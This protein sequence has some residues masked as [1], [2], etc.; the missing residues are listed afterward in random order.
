MIC[1]NSLM[2]THYCLLTGFGLLLSITSF[3]FVL[4][5]QPRRGRMLMLAFVFVGLILPKLL[6]FVVEISVAMS[7]FGFSDPNILWI[8]RLVTATTWICRLVGS[9]LLLSY[10]IC[11]ARVKPNMPFSERSNDAPH[12]YEQ[13]DLQNNFA[14]TQTKSLPPSGPSW[15]V[16]PAPKLNVKIL[17]QREWGFIID[18]LPF[19][20][21]N[22]VIILIISTQ[23][24]SS[25]FSRNTFANLLWGIF[26]LVVV[27]QFVYAL[28][29]DCA[30]GRSLG[31]CFTGCR[32]VDFTTGKPAP[33][34]Q[35]IVRNL[36]FLI[37]FF[38]IVELAT[39][40]LRPDSRRLGDLMAG[41]IVVTGPPDFVDGEPVAPPEITTPQPVK[42]H[43]LDD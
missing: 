33:A 36:P 17:R 41:T 15:N 35:T 28:F 29:K 23:F 31:K 6:S 11:I 16:P 12:R 21:G 8:Y 7:T 20:V 26:S 9:G 34:G 32:V 38:S 2:I 19:I 22:F 27:L 25:G 4:S 40:S 42:K 5:W 37:P 30:R 1:Y 14:A 10:V 43:P 13:S 3:L 18:F 39:A 24:N